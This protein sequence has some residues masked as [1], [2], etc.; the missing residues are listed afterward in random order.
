MVQGVLSAEGIQNRGGGEAV[1]P[2]LHHS[3]DSALK[4]VQREYKQK[5]HF[6][7][8]GFWYS[9]GDE[10]A[11][12]CISEEFCDIAGYC[13]YAIGVDESRILKIATPADLLLFTKA[14][15]VP[16]PAR[17]LYDYNIDWTRV[18]AM[19]GG[20]EIAPYHYSMRLDCQTSWYYPWDVASGCVWDT[21]AITL[22]TKTYEPDAVTP[23]PIP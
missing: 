15:E 18:A 10:W 22:C 11:K 23:T 19:Y 5:H 16:F 13:I 17:E 7:P 21:S 8:V 2:R 4:I 14:F 20:I 12:W 3:Q 6:K 1:I 9:V